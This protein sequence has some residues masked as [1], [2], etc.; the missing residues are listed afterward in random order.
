MLW[1]ESLKGAS[2]IVCSYHVMY[3]FQRE[4]TLLAWSRCEIWSLSDCNW[5]QTHNHLVHTWTLNHLTKWLSV[6]LWTKWLWVQV[7]LQ[8]PKLLG[9]FFHCTLEWLC[10]YVPTAS[11]RLMLLRNQVDCQCYKWNIKTVKQKNQQKNTTY[12]ILYCVKLDWFYS[13]QIWELKTIF[14][15]W[16]PF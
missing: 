4:S 16:K 8:L 11:F 14:H 5:T 15:Q 13:I 12:L 1:K 10:P 9:C 2:R 3:A 7:Q 6:H